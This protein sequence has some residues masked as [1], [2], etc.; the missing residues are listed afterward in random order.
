M[1]ITINHGRKYSTDISLQRRTVN[2]EKL[3]DMVY[4]ELQLFEFEIWKLSTESGLCTLTYEISQTRL[5]G[6]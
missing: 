4:L 2:K 1:Y 3:Q 5:S 6:L